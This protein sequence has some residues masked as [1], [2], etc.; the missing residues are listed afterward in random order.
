MKRTHFICISLVALC[1]G[2]WLIPVNSAPEKSAVFSKRWNLAL[3]DSPSSS[4]RETT[5]ADW[6]EELE[7]LTRQARW[8]K[9]SAKKGEG[10]VFDGNVSVEKLPEENK[11]DMPFKASGL[12]AAAAGRGLSKSAD[13][14]AGRHNAATV[15]E[16]LKWAEKLSAEV[17]E[18]EAR[19]YLKT[20]KLGEYAVGP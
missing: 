11:N 16:Q 6:N 5:K 12:N 8:L 2:I 15:A 7:V 3:R 4:A 18:E 17:T 20:H 9:V 19:N 13:E 10:W 14:Y 1:L